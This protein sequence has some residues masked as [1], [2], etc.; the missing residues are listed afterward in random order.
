MSA[1]VCWAAPA[2]AQTHDEPWETVELGLTAALDLADGE[3]H[4]FWDPGPTLGAQATF[5][6]N[7]GFVEA[8]VHRSTYRARAAGQPSFASWF[9]FAGW[10]AEARLVPRVRWRNGLRLGM[11]AMRFDDDAI[12][13]EAR[14]ETELAGSLVSTLHVAAGGRWT[15]QLGIAYHEIFTSVPVRQVLLGAGASYRFGTPSW[16]RDF[17]D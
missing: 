14:R 15:A 11:S 13:P 16:L 6:F 12:A 4:R 5:P 8:G 3:L 9:V 7:W 10:S 17:L 1:A 2:A